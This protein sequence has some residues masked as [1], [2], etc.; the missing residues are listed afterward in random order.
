MRPNTISFNKHLAN[1]GTKLAD[2][3]N[4]SNNYKD[5]LHNQL[6]N[7][8]VMEETTSFECKGCANMKI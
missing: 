2:E 1:V 8:I 3:I 7:S 4:S 5:Y 6:T